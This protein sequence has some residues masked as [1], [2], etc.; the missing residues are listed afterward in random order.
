MLLREP[1]QGFDSIF[2]GFDFV[3]LQA[4]DTAL[5][6][7]NELFVVD[8]EQPGARRGAG[9]GIGSGGGMVHTRWCLEFGG[10]GQTTNPTSR[11]GGYG[12]RTRS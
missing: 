12:P 2:S 4:Q 7:A 9:W 6:F 3:S 10:D 8:D 5:K 1:L 11:G